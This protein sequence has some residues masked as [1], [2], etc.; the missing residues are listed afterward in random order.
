MNLIYKN[1]ASLVVLEIIRNMSDDTKNILKIV[2]NKKWPNLKSKN[3]G[4]AFYA[5][6]IQDSFD[7]LDKDTFVSWN[8]TKSE[9]FKK[10]KIQKLAIILYEQLMLKIDNN[11]AKKV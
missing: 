8:K 9:K 11:K 10:N 2:C 3:D 5:S 1:E 4:S 7:I 6:C